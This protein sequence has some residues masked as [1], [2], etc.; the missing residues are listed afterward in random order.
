MSNSHER[1]G[2]DNLFRVIQACGDEINQLRKICDDLYYGRTGAFDRLT[3]GMAAYEDYLS[4]QEDASK[5]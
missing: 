4:D 1:H 2:V 3:E 5:I